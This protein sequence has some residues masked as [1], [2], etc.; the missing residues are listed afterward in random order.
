[1]RILII[2]STIMALA[3][4]LSCGG[5][6]GWLKKIGPED[7]GTAAVREEPQARQTQGTVVGRVLEVNYNTN[8]VSVRQNRDLMMGSVVFVV[9]G[10]REIMMTVTFPMQSMSKCQV[11]ANQR[12]YAR[13]IKKDMVVYIR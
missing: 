9:T 3:F 12:Q 13:D 10:T 4:A 7:G 6:T 11:V 8:E 5:G 2:V 1:M